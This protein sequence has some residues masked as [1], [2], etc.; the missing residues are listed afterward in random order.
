MPFDLYFLA[1]VG[2]IAYLLNVWKKAGRE[3]G[4]NEWH[5][6][7]DL[8]GFRQRNRRLRTTPFWRRC[9]LSNL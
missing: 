5:N 9:T 4:W 3:S 7:K 1:L 6:G 8:F 2:M